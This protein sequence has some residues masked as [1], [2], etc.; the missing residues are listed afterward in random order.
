M[1]GI[2][3]PL[4][5]RETTTTMLRMVPVCPG[6]EG[7]LPVSRYSPGETGTAPCVVVPPIERNCSRAASLRSAAWLVVGVGE[8]TTVGM[9]TNRFVPVPTSFGIL[10]SV[11]PDKTTENIEFGRSAIGPSDNALSD[12]E[13]SAVVADSGTE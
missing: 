10:S 12:K 2:N 3:S 1:S 13:S 6:G 4:S 7:I 8:A 9:T 5:L 11:A